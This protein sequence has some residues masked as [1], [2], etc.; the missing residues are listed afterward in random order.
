[1][2]VAADKVVSKTTSIEFVQ[3]ADMDA[4]GGGVAAAPTAAQAEAA[5]QSARQNYMAVASGGGDVNVAETTSQ[6]IVLEDNVAGGM[7]QNIALEQIKI[8]MDV[9]NVTLREVMQRIVQQAAAYSG[10][11]TVKWRL[12]PENMPLLEERVNLTAEADF[13]DFTSL[14][15]ER[16]KNM[17]GTQLYVTAF[18]GTRVLLVA[19]TY[20]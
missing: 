18:G 9:D 1:M 13:G 4:R 11:W 12:R 15:A 19:D 14:L 16:V 6:S 7:P 8:V 5:Y 10:P 2:I 20:Y 17:T 3:A